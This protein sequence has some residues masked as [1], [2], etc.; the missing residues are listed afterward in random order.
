MVTSHHLS[1]VDNFLLHSAHVGFFLDLTRFRHCA[2]LNLPFGHDYRPAP[3]LLSSVYL[4]ALHVH[5]L[6]PRTRTP[7]GTREHEKALLSRSLQQAASALS[8]THPHRV[9]HTIQAEILLAYYFFANGRF[10]EGQYHSSA[11]VSLAL[12]SGLDRIRGPSPRSSAGN[13][14]LRQILPQPQ[15]QVE[16]GERIACFW[17]IAILELCWAVSLN[18]PSNIPWPDEMSHSV[19][20]TPWPLSPAEYA[21]ACINHFVQGTGL[22]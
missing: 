20:D 10:L 16:E 21:Q 8:G 3:A 9:L 22:Y 12:S 7:I 2:L 15:D 17:N 13:M 1:R 14:E 6:G 19:I 11:A 18:S 5:V 4:W